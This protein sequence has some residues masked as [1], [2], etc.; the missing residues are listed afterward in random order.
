L[1]WGAVS[2]GFAFISTSLGFILIRL[3]L[4][5]LE[6]GYLTGV[7]YYVTL[8]LP[9]THLT[10]PFAIID[11]G[12]GFSQVVAPGLTVGLLSLDGKADLMGW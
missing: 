7:W 10:V 1:G 9:H 8:I 5:I 6:A 3:L 11:L 2:V 4:G 12:E